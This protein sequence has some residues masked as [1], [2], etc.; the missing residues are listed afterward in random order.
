MKFDILDLVMSN[1]SIY[2]LKFS[3][4]SYSIELFFSIKIIKPLYSFISSEHSFY[5]IHLVIHKYDSH[6]KN[7]LWMKIYFGK[8]H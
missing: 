3:I 6:Y 2:H 1:Y 8:Y 4:L 7:S 5:H